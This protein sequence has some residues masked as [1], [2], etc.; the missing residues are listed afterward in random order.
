MRQ[1]GQAGKTVKPKVDLAFGI[2]AVQH[3]AGMTT[4]ET[5]I[6]VDTDPEGVDLRCHRDLLI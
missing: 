3:L 2:S 1:V 4:S 6:A 5:T